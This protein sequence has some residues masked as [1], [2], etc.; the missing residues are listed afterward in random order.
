MK[1]IVMALLQSVGGIVNVAIVVM[2][3]WMMFAILAVNLFGGK[4][5]YCTIDTFMMR[6]KVEC[7]K[8]RGDWMTY[9]YNFDSV[10]TA[11][12]TMFSLATLENWPDIM[13]N[14]INSQ[15]ENIGPKLNANPSNGY[16]FV[17][18][19]FIGS[20]LFLNLFVG[21]IFKEFEDA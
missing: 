3:V 2:V 4:L 6:N 14:T 5:Q 21:V 15:G 12:I 17:V 9:D 7:L 19:I 10:P 18:Y 8:N 13:Y 16:F 20:F 1:T 11:M